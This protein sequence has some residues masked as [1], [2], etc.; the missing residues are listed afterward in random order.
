MPRRLPAGHCSF[1]T[2]LSSIPDLCSVLRSRHSAP[3]VDYPGCALLPGFVNAHTHLEL[4]HFSSWLHKSSVDYAPRRFTDWIIQLIK[5][6]RGLTPEDYPPSIRE[7]IRMCLESGTTAI[8]EIVTN[9]AMAEHYYRSPLAG[10]LYFELLGQ[11]KWL[12]QQKLAAADNRCTSWRSRNAP[13]RP[14]PP[15]TLYDCGGASGCNW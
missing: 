5:V 15:F 11:E 6:A 7:G 9:P 14:L 8:G 12:F 10:R 3:V 4:T 1:A 2:V 13:F